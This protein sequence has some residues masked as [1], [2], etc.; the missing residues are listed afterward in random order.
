MAWEAR[1][2]LKQA[3]PLAEQRTKALVGMAWE[4]RSGLKPETISHKYC[5]AFVVGMA[6]EARSGLKLLTSSRT[7]RC[8]SL[9]EWPG[10]PVRD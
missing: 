10:K 2:G 3:S 1:S 4:A 9:S 8:V 6:W 7:L 5:D